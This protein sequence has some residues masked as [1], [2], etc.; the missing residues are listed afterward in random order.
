[1]P[2]DNYRELILDDGARVR[3]ELAPVGGS[4]PPPPAP[5]DDLP[6]GVGGGTPA[7]RGERVAA[8]ATDTLAAV[9]RPLGP[10]LQQVHDSVRDIQDPPETLTVGFGLQIGHDLK[11]GIVGTNGHASMTVSATWQLRPDG[12]GAA[13][14][15]SGGN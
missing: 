12:A 4:G 9:L 10:V 8:L 13:T 7:G 6:G 14:T 3:V 1:M 11:I 5:D 15:G 2:H